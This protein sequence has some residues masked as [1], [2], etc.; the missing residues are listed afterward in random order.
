MSQLF[1]SGGQSTEASAS[2][3]ICNDSFL[4][5]NGSIF[6]KST[7]LNVWLLDIFHCFL[8]CRRCAIPWLKKK[9]RT[10]KPKICNSSQQHF[11]D[12]IINNHCLMSS[13][14]TLHPAC[15]RNRAESSKLS[16][17]FHPQ[18]GCTRTGVRSGS[19]DLFL[20]DSAPALPTMLSWHQQK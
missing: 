16:L 4:Y 8:P 1:A 11:K 15:I 20:S 3:S 19:I 13:W 17:M 18:C 6:W 9:K 5:G 12:T 7:H 2:A 10:T 14:C